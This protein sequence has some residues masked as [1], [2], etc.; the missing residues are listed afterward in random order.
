MFNFDADT[1]NTRGAEADLLVDNVEFRQQVR[2]GGRGGRGSGG[3]DLW[4]SGH[5]GFEN[6]GCLCSTDGRVTKEKV[7]VGMS[8]LEFMDLRRP[9]N[10]TQIK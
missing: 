2:A 10:I 3:E 6:M 9:V 5:D 4:V 7:D 1:T 8:P